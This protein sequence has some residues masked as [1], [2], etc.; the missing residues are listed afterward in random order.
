MQELKQLETEMPEMEK[1]KAVLVQKLSKG[2]SHEELMAWSVEIEEINDS[3]SEK[4]MR[5][6]ELSELSGL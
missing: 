2:G 4:E 1:R 3:V 6:L 5:W